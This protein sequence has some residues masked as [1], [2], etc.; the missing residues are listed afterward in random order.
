MIFV[1]ELN[2]DDLY[3][4]SD[5]N[6]CYSGRPW[7]LGRV[8]DG[9]GIDVTSN[10]NLY[11]VISIDCYHGMQCFA[12]LV[13][14]HAS[15]RRRRSERVASRRDVPHRRR[16]SF[17]TVYAFIRLRYRVRITGTGLTVL[18]TTLGR[19]D[20]P[21]LS[22]T[23]GGMLN[24]GNSLAL[25]FS[26]SIAICFISPRTHRDTSARGGGRPSTAGAGLRHRAAP[27]P[28]RR[29]RAAHPRRVTSHP[30]QGFSHRFLST[31]ILRLFL[32]S[33][34]AVL[35]DKVIFMCGRKRN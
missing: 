9:I 17:Y 16:S 11:F 26:N 20:T 30:P 24:A 13:A 14:A 22:L 18:G 15:C 1:S 6:R 27:P 3:I 31:R 7:C 8:S 29:H 28:P 25:G 21:H 5:L 19:G 2:L 23:G 34:T 10:R 33:E 32:S 4:V 35:F 12:F